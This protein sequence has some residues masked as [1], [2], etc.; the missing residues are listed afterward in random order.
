MSREE[1]EQKLRDYRQVC[2]LTIII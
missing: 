2:F 1:A